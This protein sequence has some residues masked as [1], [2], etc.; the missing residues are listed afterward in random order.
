MVFYSTSWFS[1]WK[2][3]CWYWY[4]ISSIW[5]PFHCCFPLARMK[6]TG[7]WMNLDIF[8]NGYIEYCFQIKIVFLYLFS[9]MYCPSP[10]VL[11]ALVVNTPKSFCFIEKWFQLLLKK[12]CTASYVIY[13][14]N[15]LKCL[16][17]QL[18]IY[19]HISLLPFIIII[20]SFMMSLQMVK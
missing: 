14:I 4:L 16:L 3:Y 20:I 6:I 12:Q 11:V 15:T 17:P 9:K 10:N 5:L 13:C 18:L 2:E 1:N 19:F 8:E 7:H